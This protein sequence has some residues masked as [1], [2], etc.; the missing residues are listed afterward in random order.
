MAG[1]RA[2]RGASSPVLPEF[3]GKRCTA[4]ITSVRR[5]CHRRH[6][7]V[8]TTLP[9]CCEAANGEPPELCDFQRL[10]A[11]EASCHLPRQLIYFSLTRKAV[12]KL[13]N[14]NAPETDVV[15]SVQLMFLSGSH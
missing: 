9:S 2:Y 13:D 5:R 11:G 7:R 14:G 3:R 1:N 10:D 15:V 12:A 8:V 6:H 4:D